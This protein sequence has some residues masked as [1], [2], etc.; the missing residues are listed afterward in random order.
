MVN[1][2]IAGHRKANGQEITWQIVTL[3]MIFEGR[4]KPHHHLI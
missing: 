2:Q 4:F 1:N 3:Q